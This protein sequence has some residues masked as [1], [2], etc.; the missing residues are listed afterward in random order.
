MA[1]T[2]RVLNIKDGRQLI[3]LRKAMQSIPAT[4]LAMRD[5]MAN[6]IENVDHFA[7][8]DRDLLKQTVDS[9]NGRAL[10]H[11][12]GH[13]NIE[14]LAE[15]AEAGLIGDGVKVANR[16]GT[17]L[18]ATSAAPTTKAYARAARTCIVSSVVLRRTTTC[19]VLV[20]FAK[21]ERWAGPGADEKVAVTISEAAK[22]DI[23]AQALEGYC[24]RAPAVAVAA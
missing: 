6:K 4:N 10:S 23:I 12:Y 24:V 13:H 18:M 22:N 19:W 11:T 7:H 20:S 5:S 2:I 21:T 14:A 3:E 9:V 16:P 1:K 15:A 17:T 8:P